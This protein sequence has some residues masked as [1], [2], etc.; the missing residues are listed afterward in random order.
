MDKQLTEGELM[1]EMTRRIK[2]AGLNV[3]CLG[4][5]KV[6]SKYLIVAEAPGLREVEMHLPLVG[7]AGQKLW[8]E[9]NRYGIRRSDCYVTNV[10]K[11]QVSFSTKTDARVPVGAV[12]LGHWEGLLDWEIDQL[13]NVEY[14]LILG[15][16]ALKAII[17]ENKITSWRGSIVDVVIGRNKKKVIGGIAFN[18]A[19]V[20]RDLKQEPIF[21][22]DIKKFSQVISGEYVKHIV[23]SIINPTPEE[24]IA[25][26]EK[27]KQEQK[28]VA[29][30]IETMS[31]ETACV[32]FANNSN[33]GMCIN[34]RDLDGNR[35][36]VEEE[37]K[38]RTAIQ[39]FFNCGLKFIAQNGNFDSYWLWYK[40]GIR[41]PGI[42]FDTL[43]AH[44]T[45]YPLLPH[46]LGYLTAQYTFHPYYKDEGKEW[47]ERGDIDQFWGYNVKDCCITWAV[48]E[49]LHKELVSQNMAEFFF[50]HVMRLQPHLTR[51]TV[52][53]VKADLVLKE[54]ISDELTIEVEKKLN[55]FHVAVD[56]ATGDNE[57]KPNPRS[58]VQLKKLLFDTLRLVG[59]GKSTGKDNR[60]RMKSH[61]RCREVDAKVLDTL[62]SYKKDHKFLTTYIKSKV[63]VD[64]RIRCEYKQ[65]GTQ[66]APGRLSSAMTMWKSG[67]NLQNQPKKAYPMF[68]ADNGYMLSYF[69]LKQAEA[70]FVAY[71]WDVKGLI[72]NFIRAE[73]EE[74]FDVHRGNAASIF[75]VP[76]NEIPESDY[77]K[78][79]E[80]TKRY[81]GK[82]CVHGLNYRMS[83]LKLAEVCGI[84]L[85]Q[86]FEAYSAYHRAFPEIREAWE[87]IIKR[88]RKDRV[89]FTPLGRRLIILGQIID[90]TLDSVIAF[91][92]QSTIGDKVSSVIYQCHDDPDWPDNARMIL[93]IH[94]ALIA[95]HLPKDREII[96]HIMKKH[97]EAPIIIH[98]E[99]VTIFTDFKESIADEGG[100]H[101][102]STLKDITVA[103]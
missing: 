41:P 62:D 55:A 34:F 103:A 72:K 69:D 4:H 71:A 30:D 25:Y 11:R 58:P 20:L 54:K 86:A 79:G 97:A 28:P 31:G 8:R 98:G 23:K 2:A 89:L 80:R 94:D 6:E 38:V 59:R 21:C 83:P 73:H 36:S 29:F 57:Y 17:G 49:K 45:L 66:S 81:L 96:Q 13:P 99:P 9:L 101:R 48:H 68:I 60:E 26:L 3:G 87:E 74:G 85:S 7:G 46:N 12:E 35:W 88:V 102:W 64:G 52:G 10:V 61:P 77:D 47:K 32:G 91:E 63:D 15:G 92:P 56:N 16:T 44:H 19:H 5:G 90:D 95:I 22:F 84:P 65:Y 43:L 53:G 82:R 100:V 75:K 33:E 40:D 93:N 50:N 18:P 70:K 37:L 24:A 14:I 27:L 39:D 1:Q 67:M 51:M 42:W 76:Y 78:N